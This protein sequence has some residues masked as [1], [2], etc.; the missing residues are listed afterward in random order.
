MDEKGFTLKDAIKRAEER[1]RIQDA[2]DAALKKKVKTSLTYQPL[3]RRVAK[4][5]AIGAAFGLAGLGVVGIII[6][7][8][9][10]DGLFGALASGSAPDLIGYSAVLL[11][12]AVTAAFMQWCVMA[13]VAI[14]QVLAKPPVEDNLIRVLS[15]L[16][17]DE[18]DMDQ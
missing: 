4:Y 17:F 11:A 5:L 13:M 10:C 3:A 6:A 16:D 7:A 1:Q 12:G 2:K 15:D 9:G 18:V 14:Y 8:R